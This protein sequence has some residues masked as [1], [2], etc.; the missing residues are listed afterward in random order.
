[1]YIYNNDTTRF[2]L[3]ISIDGPH[4]G[5]YIHHTEMEW[6][7]GVIK[8]SVNGIEHF[9]KFKNKGGVIVFNHPTFF[10][11]SVLIQVTNSLLSFL[12]KETY[13]SAYPLKLLSERLGCI[14]VDKGNTVSKVKEAI[15]TGKTIA[16]SP[17]AGESFEDQV[18]LPQFRTGAFVASKHILPLAIS[19]FPYERWPSNQ[20]ILKAIYKRLTSE[21]LQYHVSILP[22]VSKETDESHEDFADRVR[23]QMEDALRVHPSLETPLK[24]PPKPILV[25]SSIVFGVCAYLTYL[26]GKYVHALGILI[27]F[28]T[29]IWYHSTGSIHAKFLDTFSN[30]TL[31]IVFTLHGLWQGN[32]IMCAYAVMA[33]LGFVTFKSK[34]T[35]GHMIGVHI[36]V[37]LGFL[38][39][40]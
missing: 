17:S 12:V 31:G 10:D 9:E 5:H 22:A 15:L 26:A 23:E 25:L 8:G 1:M 4:R 33:V 29:S 2:S 3:Y 6:G 18:K 7:L 37:I 11:H 21:F 20:P 27:V 28:I 14:S 35:I 16:I 30:F 36:P 13:V 39:L 19:Y 32:Y 38:T 24:E 34:H 40:V